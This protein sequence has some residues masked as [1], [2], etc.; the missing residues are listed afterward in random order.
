MSRKLGF[1]VRLSDREIIRQ[2]V[3]LVFKTYF[4]RLTGIMDCFEIFTER[5]KRLLAGQQMYSHYKKHSTVKVLIV[6]S[7]NGAIN[8][9]SKC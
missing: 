9:M 1:L 5:P 6:C 8:F 4:P 2:T 7:P 3:P